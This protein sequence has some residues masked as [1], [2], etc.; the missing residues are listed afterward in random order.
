MS[1]I[2]KNDVVTIDVTAVSNL[3]YGVGRT[4]DGKVVFTH[5][6]VSGERAEVKIIKITKGYLVGRLMKVVTPSPLRESSDRCTAPAS[7]GGCA[8]RFIKYSHEL[9]L[10][11]QNVRSELDKAGLSHV[12]VLE[13]A[14]TGEVWGYRN[15][16]QYR[17]AAYEGGIRAGF[18][19]SGTHRVTGDESCPLQPE[20]FG[21]IAKFVCDF[22]YKKGISV[23]DEESGKGLLRHLYLRTGAGEDGEILVCI[24]I[25]G[26]SLPHAD[27]LAEALMRTFS[28]IVG[29]VLNVNTKNSNV[30]LG[31]EYI[32]VAGKASIRD[33]FCGVELDVAPAAFYQVNHDAAELLC[34]PAA[35]MAGL[36]GDEHLLD[37]YCGIGSVGL[38]MAGRVGRLTG[39]E[40]VPE[41]VECAVANAA[42]AGIEN[43]RFLCADSALGASELL[44]VAG[45]LPDVVVLDPPR[46]GCAAELLDTLDRAG[47]KKIVYISCNPATLARD[48][49][50]L[51]QLGW[52]IG[53]VLPVDLFPRTGHVESVVSLTRRLDVDMRR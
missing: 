46:K 20:I 14:H 39:V 29:V 3:G 6:A 21:K 50:H 43:A 31:N 15:K 51:Y 53:T 44:G 32:T 4:E 22:A 48:L 49:A 10:K 13:T 45:E 5:G 18:Y 26:R 1:D 42:R 37:L 23:Y 12:E 30:I 9:E 36:R 17:F 47:V 25:A 33:V 38:S 27:E 52:S 7:C 40:I 16:A 34:R 41:A 35:D 2:K 24:V 8:Y 19:A 28:R 11:R